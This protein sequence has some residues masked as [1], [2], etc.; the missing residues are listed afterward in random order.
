LATVDTSQKEVAQSVE[1][2]PACA[3]F[4]GLFDAEFGY[5]CRALRRLGVQA[6]DLEDVA[7]ELFVTVHRSLDEYDPGRP[8]RPWLFSFALRYA[9]NYRR[10][11]RNQ[12]HVSDEA[13]HGFAAGEGSSA[14][15]RD[16]VLRA[17]AAL[18]F[19]R[20]TIMIMHDLE[21]FDAPEIASQVGIPLNT[22]Y[23]R[24]RLAR[25]D[26]RT[27]VEALQSKGGSS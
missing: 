24:L 11:A 13:L 16:V 25:T 26:F 7:Q 15:A 23:S 22:V 8:L 21:G 17:L 9:A 1:N 27:A 3:R 20:R 18:D 19:E 14:E 2:Y 6:G 12:G 10:L 4:R 5:V